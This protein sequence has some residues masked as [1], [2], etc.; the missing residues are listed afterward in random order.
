MSTTVADH[1]LRRLRAWGIEQVFDYPGDGI[2]GLLAAW[3][4]AEDQ[5]RFVQSRHAEMS[6]FQ[7]V[8]YA[9]FSGRLGVCAAT[10]GPGTIHLL[11]GLYDAELDHVPVVGSSA[12]RTAAIGVS[13]GRAQPRAGEGR[14]VPAGGRPAHPVQGR[15]L[16]LRRDGDR[17][18]AAAER[19][20][21]G[22]PHGVC[23]PRADGRHHPRGRAGAGVH[24]ADPRVQDGPLQPGP[25]LVDGGALPGVGRAGRRDPERRGQ[26]RDPHRAGHRRGPRRGRADRRTARRGR[27][28]GPPRSRTRTGRRSPWSETARCR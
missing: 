24:T 10:S 1:I 4:R 19:P 9:K 13:P 18:R 8:G 14:L 7:A 27:R 25:R 12:R 11:N 22:D 2:N 28:Q 16:G 20:R 15:G 3:G 6:A 26:G 21:P 5:P 17:A 23:P